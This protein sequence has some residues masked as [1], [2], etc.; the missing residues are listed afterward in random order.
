MLV[1]VN[2]SCPVGQQVPRLTAFSMHTPLGLNTLVRLIAL[3]HLQEVW[4]FLSSSGEGHESGTLPAAGVSSPSHAASRVASGAAAGASGFADTARSSPPVTGHAG[5][6]VTRNS[7]VDQEPP[8]PRLGSLT[9]LQRLV[10]ATTVAAG[11][12]P[13]QE[14]AIQAASAAELVLATLSVS[15]S[16]ADGLQTSAHFDLPELGEETAALL[17]S[18]TSTLPGSASPRGTGAE[19]RSAEGA[20]THWVVRHRLT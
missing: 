15:G 10:P 12:L 1:P 16:S 18:E 5:G 2:A 4:H 17:G 14:D 13:L 3:L 9:D 7:Q 19:G 20:G 6:Q 11:A 8:V